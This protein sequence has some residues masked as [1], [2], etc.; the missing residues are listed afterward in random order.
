M[1]LY[2]VR[3]GDAVSEEVDRTRPLSHEGKAT[4]QG[5]ASF[6]GQSGVR[7]GRVLHSG[8]KRAEQTAKLLAATLADIGQRE[9]MEGLKPHDP[10]APIVK[11]IDEWIED[12]MIVGH[13]PFVGNLVAH[14]VGGSKTASLILF[15]P[16]TTVCLVRVEDEAWMILWVLS[17]DLLADTER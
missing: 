8:K 10:V 3:H 9:E 11:A 5:V 1:R 16:V 12:T 7:V 13:L 6:L 2:V 15:Q 4:V 14:L 17:P